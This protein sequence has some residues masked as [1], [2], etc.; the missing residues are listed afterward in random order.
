MCYKEKEVIAKVL[1]TAKNADLFW[2]RLKKEK[3]PVVRE[4]QSGNSD[5]EKFKERVKE[6]ENQLMISSSYLNR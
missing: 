2:V 5:L 3:I 6:L 4:V 1:V